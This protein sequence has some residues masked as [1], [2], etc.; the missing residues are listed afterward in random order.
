MRGPAE[1]GEERKGSPGGASPAPAPP[2]LI[3]FVS[4]P[5]AG[6]P[7]V[8]GA[9]SPGAGGAGRGRG[10]GARRRFAG[11]GGAPPAALRLA[12]HPP[13]H[14][15]SLEGVV[16]FQP[17]GGDLGKISGQP[18]KLSG[19]VLRLQGVRRLRLGG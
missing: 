6:L 5:G 15:T 2:R 10:G 9:R 18:A 11:G 13:W 14:Q 8:P 16:R 1:A 4:G 12:V 7:A 3:G 19:E 17:R